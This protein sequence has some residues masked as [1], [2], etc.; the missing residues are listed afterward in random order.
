[1][2]SAPSTAATDQPADSAAPARQCVG[3]GCSNPA[4]KG[5][6]GRPRTYCSRSCRSTVDRVKAKARQ[7]VAETAAPLPA[8]AAEPVPAA[9]PDHAAPAVPAAAVEA[10]DILVR[11]GEDGRH[12]L[13]IADAKR[14]RPARFLE[15]S[16]GGDPAEAFAEL[17]RVLPVY[18]TRAYMAA[19]EIRDK[20]RWPH[21]ADR[22][23]GPRRTRRRRIRRR[24]RPGGDKRPGG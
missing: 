16:A 22:P 5:S 7:A 14:R 6:T 15:E 2:D 9:A 3:P 13:G 21:L 4:P 20:A 19:Q 12:L 18:G 11:W 24:C 8:P 1:M 23:L 17:A 10:D